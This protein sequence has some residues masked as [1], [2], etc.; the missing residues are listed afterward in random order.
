[1]WGVVVTFARPATL[2]SML[3]S[4]ERQTRPV[5][6]LLV[7]DNGSD[8]RVAAIAA[9]HAADYLDSGG[10]I[11]PAGGIALGMQHVLAR[12][13]EGDWILLVDDDD[14]P[15]DDDLLRQLWI[16]GEGEH[17]RDGRVG[18]VAVAGS[19][20]RRNLG[21]FRRLE[22]DELTGV[23]DLDVLFGGS[24]PMYRVSAAREVG[25][26]DVDLFWGFEEGEYGLRMR[27]RGYRLCAPGPA[28]L[29]SRE[30]GGTGG[31]ESRNV[32]TPLEKAAWRRYYSIRNSTVLARRYGGPVA[33]L[34]TSV[35]GAGKGV[36]AMLRA[37]RPLSEVALAP[38]GALH[39]L[40]G[41]LGR[42]VDPGRND[43]GAAAAG[44]P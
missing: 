4:L 8:P 34:I 12:A 25:G 23:V 32:R 22:D 30:L 26:F 2:E 19:V 44:P 43:K 36:L 6:H 5:D 14:E 17:S 16:F 27:S 18:G 29:R 15:A 38:R 42:R 9:S 33:P 31:V 21:I 1:M 41:R 7:V 13:A 37:G 24:L 3:N 28:F 20:Y 10:N 40:T 11:G 35:G 39:G